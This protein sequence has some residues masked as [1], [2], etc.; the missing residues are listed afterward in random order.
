AI[1]G[2]RN[3]AGARAHGGGIRGLAVY[4]A[5]VWGRHRHLRPSQFF[6]A[7]ADAGA[8]VQ[9]RLSHVPGPYAGRG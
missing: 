7:G 8:G 9:L 2:T 6:S 5:P 3:R 1:A 4:S